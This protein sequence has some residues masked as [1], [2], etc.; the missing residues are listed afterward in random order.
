MV[1]SVIVFQL[2]CKF[3]S[4]KVVVPETCI[5]RKDIAHV[6]PTTGRLKQAEFLRWVGTICIN[7]VDNDEKSHQI[8]LM[9][10]IYGNAETVYVWLGDHADGSELVMTLLQ[11]LHLGE[12]SENRAMALCLTDEEQP[13]HKS[14]AAFFDRQYWK[15]LWIIQELLCAKAAMVLCGNSTVPFSAILKFWELVFKVG[16]ACHWPNVSGSF[17]VHISI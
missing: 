14:I 7:Q 4:F 16:S 17:Q 9:R 3:Q 1:L 15:H 12:I 8:E 10:H 11:L 6:D 5:L 13:I 2:F